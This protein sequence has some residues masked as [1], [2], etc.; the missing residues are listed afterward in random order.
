MGLL[1]KIRRIASPVPSFG[2]TGPIKFR[3]MSFGTVDS[4]KAYLDATMAQTKDGKIIVT[5]EDAEQ[6]IDYLPTYFEDKEVEYCDSYDE[7][8]KNE[9]KLTGAIHTNAQGSP[10]Y[11]TMIPVMTTGLTNRVTGYLAGN[12]SSLQMEQLTE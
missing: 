3:S 1:S 12:L 9:L 6:I 7:Y 11:G 10:T 4:L 2:N 5:C 8:Y